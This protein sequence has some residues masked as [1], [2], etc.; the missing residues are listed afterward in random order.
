MQ[1]IGG[2]V[3]ARIRRFRQSAGAL[4]R[5]LGS[6]RGAEADWAERLLPGGK[7]DACAFVNLCEQAA[8]SP[9][10]TELLRE[11]QRIETEVLLESFL[12]R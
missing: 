9:S 12:A 1:N 10:H 6:R 7:W 4:A 11:I 8:S 2:A 5:F 3:S